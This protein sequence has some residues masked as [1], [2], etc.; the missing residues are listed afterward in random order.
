MSDVHHDAPKGRLS[1]RQCTVRYLVCFLAFFSGIALLNYSIDPLW[2]FPH[3]NR[4][5]VRQVKIDERQQKTNLITC[6][7][8]DFDAVLIGSSR[9][10]FI[11]YHDFKGYRLFNYAM[12]ATLPEEYADYIMYARKQSRP[13][14]KLIV[15]GLDFFGTNSN[16][17]GYG[18]KPPEEY[19]RNAQSISYRVQSLLAL[20]TL[21]YSVKNIRKSLGKPDGIFYSRE[22]IKS[23]I[24]APATREAKVRDVQYSVRE[25][26]K[27]MYGKNYRYKDMRKIFGDIRRQNPGIRTVVFTTPTSEPL[28]ELLVEEGRLDDYC[29]WI[30]DIVAEFGEV[31]TFMGVN[32]ITSNLDNYYDGHHFYPP[33]GKLIAAR[34]MNLPDSG[35]PDDFGQRVTRENLDRYLADVRARYH[36]PPPHDVG[37]RG[38]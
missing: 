4:F 17:Q 30:A 5:N 13:G 3:S 8:H 19:F 10:T 34:V 14:I 33:V 36:R 28:W 22:T 15:L 35:L 32:S 29:R 31:I 26:R 20:D 16:F 37:K 11:S 2:M 18:Q 21:R 1:Y 9:C 6:G 23:C 12:D 25:F 38:E 24:K 7:D 27:R